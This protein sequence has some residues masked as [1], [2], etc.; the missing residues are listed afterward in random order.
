MEWVNQFCLF[1]CKNPSIVAN[2]DQSYEL[3]YSDP[4]VYATQRLCKRKCRF[5]KLEIAVNVQVLPC[6]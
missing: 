4:K 5:L 6:S 1:L 3:M 2:Q